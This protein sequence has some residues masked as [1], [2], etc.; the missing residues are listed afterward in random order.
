[1]TF[2]KPFSST[3]T[4]VCTISTAGVNATYGNLSVGA[5]MMSRTDFTLRVWNNGAAAQPSVS[6]IAVGR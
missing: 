5:V 4:V 3:P 1:M 6:W 2:E